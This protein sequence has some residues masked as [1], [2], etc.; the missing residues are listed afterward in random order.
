MHYVLMYCINVI[1]A[2]VTLKFARDERSGPL[3]L[4]HSEP[5]SAAPIAAATRAESGATT[6][7]STLPEL[8]AYAGALLFWLRPPEA[9]LNPLL[10]S[11]GGSTSP[12]IVTFL[13]RDRTFVSPDP[14]SLTP[15]TLKS[16]S[17]VAATLQNLEKRDAVSAEDAW[18]VSSCAASA[19]S[20]AKSAG[21]NSVSTARATRTRKGAP[22]PR[23]RGKS[24]TSRT[25]PARRR[26]SAFRNVGK[27]ERKKETD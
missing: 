6:S 20:H 3:Y 4:F 11:S 18:A 26:G 19:K 16:T 2:L 21:L 17:A 8:I 13:R 25:L 10:C 7:A 22:P 1:L 15:R 27:R 14:S 9:A 12:A 24:A 5:E 23:A